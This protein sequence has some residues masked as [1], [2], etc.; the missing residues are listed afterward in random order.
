MPELLGKFARQE[1]VVPGVEHQ[2][3]ARLAPSGVTGGISRGPKGGELG[4]RHPP[5][6]HSPAVRLGERA[7]PHDPR[8]VAPR[9]HR[10]SQVQ[11][12]QGHEDVGE[13][14]AEAEPHH[15]HRRA[16]PAQQ[17]HS[18]AAIHDGLSEGGRG[19][20]RVA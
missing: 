18:G 15:A 20:Q 19:P 5:L 3:A 9:D 14:P 1:Q 16:A 8:D 13:N 17:A 7:F 11:R 6:L 12:F 4:A 2:Q 10:N